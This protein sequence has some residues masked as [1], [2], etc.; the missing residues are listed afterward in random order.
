MLGKINATIRVVG[1]GFVWSM[2]N[3]YGQFTV[4]EAVASFIH[5]KAPT[6]ISQS[7]REYIASIG[8]QIAF[9]TWG[10]GQIMIAKYAFYDHGDATM[11]LLGL[12]TDAH[13]TPKETSDEVE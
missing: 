1:V 3:M 2:A 5:N 13:T 11:K 9:A 6:Y 7:T 10:A 12:A 4:T 8:R